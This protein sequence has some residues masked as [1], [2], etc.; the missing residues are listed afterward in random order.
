M[1]LPIPAGASEA[2]DSRREACSGLSESRWTKAP[3]SARRF[4]THDVHATD[5]F[6]VTVGPASM[7]M[8]CPGLA[9]ERANARLC[10]T[11][12]RRLNCCESGDRVRTLHVL[13]FECLFKW[14]HVVP[15]RLVRD[16]AVRAH[17]QRRGCESAHS[18]AS[19]WCSVIH[20]GTSRHLRRSPSTT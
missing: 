15:R 14:Q 4:A 9:P 17:L 2:G 1:G 16:L 7:K 13:L 19:T 20:Y 11:R 5:G 10:D 6:P 8:R 18:F 3:L 12:P